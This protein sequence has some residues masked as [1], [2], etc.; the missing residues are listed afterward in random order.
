MTDRPRAAAAAFAAA[1]ISALVFAFAQTAPAAREMITRLGHSCTCLD[2]GA[3]AVEAA[4]GGVYD[5][6]L[7]DCQM[8][9]MDGY[10]ATA[11][12]RTWEARHGQGRRIP[13]VAL[14]AHAM[15]GDRNRCLAVGMDDYLTKP[16]Q[17]DDLQSI[18]EHWLEHRPGGGATAGAPPAPAA[19]AHQE[20]ALEATVSRAIPWKASWKVDRGGGDRAKPRS[21]DQCG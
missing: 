14:T 9:G 12:I 3:P 15:K 18:L 17:A 4:T 10:D 21:V 16:L 20:A 8:P 2:S 5:L 11:A 1:R 7:M 6:V 13:I 19:D